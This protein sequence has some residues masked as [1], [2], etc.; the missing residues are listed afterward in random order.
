MFLLFFHI[1]VLFFVLRTPISGPLL[2]AKSLQLYPIVYL[3]DTTPS[4][5]KSETGWLKRF[6]KR[7]GIVLCIFRENLY[8]QQQRVLI[9]CDETGL[10]RK[11]MPHKTL[12]SSREKEAKGYKKPKDRVNRMACANVNGSIKLPL[13]FIYKSA[14]P[15]CFKCIDMS[16][17]PVHYYDRK[18]SWRD[19][20]KWFY[21]NF[22]R[23]CRKALTE[24]GM[25]QKPF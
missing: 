19:S 18:S 5:F 7:H 3:N 8:L 14:R 20:T 22:V 24:K 21:Q 2:M 15:R 16:D 17:L 1:F 25:H 11:L 4:S 9:N 23:E 13:L 12:V 6:K 10:Y